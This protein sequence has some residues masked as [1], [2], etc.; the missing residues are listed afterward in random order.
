MYSTVDAAPISIT[1]G[2]KYAD[3]C[4]FAGFQ[5]TLVAYKNA[6]RTEV[7]L[8]SF[9]SGYLF[10]LAHYYHSGIGSSLLL[11]HVNWLFSY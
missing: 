1:L 11:R 5:F 10:W 9:G 6:Y 3:L 2:K 7:Q 8:T 4:S